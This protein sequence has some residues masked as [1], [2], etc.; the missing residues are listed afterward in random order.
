MSSNKLSFRLPK[1]KRKLS[2]G[3]IY[4]KRLKNGCLHVM[5]S[6]GLR[7][8]IG[9]VLLL[10][11]CSFHHTGIRLVLFFLL[12]SPFVVVQDENRYNAGRGAH[13]ILKRAE[14]A[15][16]LVN[17]LPCKFLTIL[18]KQKRILFKK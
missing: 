7:S 17:K 11:Y 5:R 15:R 8:I 13:L 4:L 6:A 10:F 1:L 2:A 18:K 16:S 3:K 12:L 14:K 9:L